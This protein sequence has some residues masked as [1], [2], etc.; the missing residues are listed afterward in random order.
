MRPSRTPWLPRPELRPA[1]GALA[2]LLLLSGCVTAG[3]HGEVVA[4]RDRLRVER[5][6]L[7]AEVSRISA[8]NEALEEERVE[9]LEHT[10]ELRETRAR[11]E[12]EIRA[13]ETDLAMREKQL[14]DSEDMLARQQARHD[15]MRQAAESELAQIRESYDALVGDLESEVEQG[16]LQLERL[17]EGAAFTLPSEVLFAPGSSNPTEAGRDVIRK[18]GR[19]LAETGQQVEVHG[20]TDAIPT[21]GALAARYPT[22]WELAAARAA[23]V[24]RLLVDAGV[25]PAMVVAVSHGAHDP[26]A[27][28]ETPE[29]R[30]E[31]RRIEITL[32]PVAS[33]AAP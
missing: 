17:R 28:N 9:L 24:V 25:D 27:S 3:T 6:D 12:R 15:Q 8:S 16:R 2:A 33:G 30:A 7:R 18:M 31:N 5:D 13:T 29:G 4:E 26:I 14:V 11:L 20:H 32:K 23:R 21:R 10:E 22:N 19:R 1:A